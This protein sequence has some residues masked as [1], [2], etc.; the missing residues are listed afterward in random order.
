MVAICVPSL[1]QS[2]AGLS[3]D[4][5]AMGLPSDENTTLTTASVSISRTSTASVVP[6]GL[7]QC[8]CEVRQHASVHSLRRIRNAR[9]LCHKIVVAETFGHAIL[10]AMV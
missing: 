9:R 4:V 6:A 1:L 8:G 2:R 10:R 3:F 5:V 7:A